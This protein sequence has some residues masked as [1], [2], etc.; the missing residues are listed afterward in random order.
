MSILGMNL[1]QLLR[2]S[3]KAFN[4]KRFQPIFNKH[5]YLIDLKPIHVFDLSF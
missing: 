5:A 1:H 4:Y 3:L 2:H